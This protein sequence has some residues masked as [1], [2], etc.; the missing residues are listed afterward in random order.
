MSKNTWLNTMSKNLTSATFLQYYANDFTISQV[1]RDVSIILIVADVLIS[2]F[3]NTY[4]TRSLQAETPLVY[5]TTLTYVCLSV[6]LSVFPLPR[7]ESAHSSGGH[8]SGQSVR[9]VRDG[10]EEGQ[11]E[12]RSTTC[13]ISA[14]SCV[15]HTQRVPSLLLNTVRV[16]VCVCVFSSVHP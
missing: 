7:G 3:K 4:S 15:T 10:S 8:S 14:L 2:D 11:H 6:H 12:V 9:D 1:S 5:L 16:C 13:H